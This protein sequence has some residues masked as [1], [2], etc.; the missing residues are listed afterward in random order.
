MIA[1]VDNDD[2]RV[3]VA[4]TSSV[5]QSQGYRNFAI[6]S[7]SCIGDI[8][9]DK[10]QFS[11]IFIISNSSAVDIT[12]LITLHSKDVPVVIL[13]RICCTATDLVKHAITSRKHFYFG[14]YPLAPNFLEEICRHYR[15]SAKFKLFQ[16]TDDIGHISPRKRV[17][18]A[19]F[20]S[21]EHISLFRAHSAQ[22]DMFANTTSEEDD[23][24]Y[25]FDEDIDQVIK[26]P[27]GGDYTGHEPMRLHSFTSYAPIRHFPCGVRNCKAVVA[28]LD[29]GSIHVFGG[30]IH[31]ATLFA[32]RSPW[33]WPSPCRQMN[34]ESLYGIAT[35][36]QAKSDIKS[37]VTK[38]CS[39]PILEV[40]L[41][42]LDG[43]PFRV[44][45]SVCPIPTTAKYETTYKIKNRGNLSTLLVFM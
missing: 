15:T 5:L 42:A 30:D 40:N 21:N 44:R 9:K 13:Y 10:D 31:F 2:V 18:N 43:Q 20:A 11:A 7:F 8:D 19:D 35:C 29:G 34:L 6:K 24:S 28:T 12:E 41:Y 25:S 4:S 36:Q 37:A 27:R 22:E 39:L 3:S 26:S 16:N 38:H 17:I 33:P 32:A 45:L 14:R 1:L 23:F